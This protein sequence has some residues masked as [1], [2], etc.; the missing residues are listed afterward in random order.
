MGLRELQ[1]IK[2]IADNAISITF[3]FLYSVMY[4]NKI[5]WINKNKFVIHNLFPIGYKSS[6]KGIYLYISG[7]R[8]DLREKNIF[9][10]CVSCRDA[11]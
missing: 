1:G 3:A 9:E 11:H 5:N 8:I 10:E 6:V 7:D 4:T 2:R